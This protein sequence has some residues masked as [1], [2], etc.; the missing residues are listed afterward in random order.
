MTNLQ[1]KAYELWKGVTAGAVMRI[2]VQ[3]SSLFVEEAYFD[4]MHETS[5]REIQQEWIIL[6]TL[7][8][9]IED[10]IDEGRAGSW[11]GKIGDC[12]VTISLAS[13]CNITLRINDSENTHELNALSLVQPN[14]TRLVLSK[15]AL[16]IGHALTQGAFYSFVN[17]P[18]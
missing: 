13:P 6:A 3:G 7:K 15:Y 2:V 16:S 8:A 14:F 17:N 9:M 4:R 11:N 12:A 5:W 10:H 18:S 1:P